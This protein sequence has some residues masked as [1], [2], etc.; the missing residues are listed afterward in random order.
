MAVMTDEQAG[1]GRE[2]RWLANKKADAVLRLLRGKRLD[3]LSRELRVEAHRLAAW[4]DE[5]RAAGKVGLKGRSAAEDGMSV[6]Q[7]RRFREA[8][9][10]V[11]ELTWTPTSCAPRR[12][13][14]GLEVPPAKRPR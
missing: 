12:D 5:F 3:Q 4:R 9:R 10:T 13:N 6:E 11:G 7:R 14:G 8:E 2:T 1:G